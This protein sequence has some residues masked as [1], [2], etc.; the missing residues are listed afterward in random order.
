MKH[1]LGVYL[2]FLLCVACISCQKKETPSAR[3]ADAAE[4][5]GPSAP[6]KSV[7]L[8]DGT[9]APDFTLQTLDGKSISLS[10]HKGKAVLLEFWA[11]WCPPCQRAFPHID[12]L[13]KDFADNPVAVVSVCTSS[14]RPDLEAFLKQHTDYSLTILFDPA[15]QN[16]SVGFAKYLIDGFPSFFIIGPDGKVVTSFKGFSEQDTSNKLKELIQQQL[17]ARQ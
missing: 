11:A 7:R 3:S 1:K 5:A 6:A 9:S 14:K 13:H 4:P 16:E 2:A 17:T 15:A 12:K 10:D 8:P